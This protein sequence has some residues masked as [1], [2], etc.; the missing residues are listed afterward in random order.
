MDPDGSGA[1]RVPRNREC[2]R[3]VGVHQSRK[4]ASGQLQ[5]CHRAA[6][7]RWQDGKPNER[8]RARRPGCAPTAPFTGAGRFLALSRAS[9]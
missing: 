9:A 7:T 4:T 6:S 2:H 5:D 3:P 1:D 8:R